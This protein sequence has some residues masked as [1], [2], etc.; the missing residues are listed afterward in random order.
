NP[1]LRVRA[2]HILLEFPDGAAAEERDSV[3]AQAE[4]L[5]SRI[6]E[7]E[8]FAELAQEYS[9]DPG[10][11]RRGG[12][13]GWFG[14]G[15]MVQPFEEAAFA[16]QPGEVS[17]VVESPFGLHI[18]R[19]DERES[20]SFEE[21]GPDFRQQAVARRQQES[22]DA[23]VE[24][25]VEPAGVEV[26]QGAVDIARDLARRPSERLAGRAASRR[27]VTWDDGAV[28][29]GEFLTV[30]QRF[31]PQQRA[32]LA[33]MPEQQVESMLETMATN[34]LVL[35]DAEARGIR[36]D[37]AQRDSVTTVLREQFV[38]LTRDAGL[39]SPP[40]EGETRQEAIDR[41]VRTLLQG[42]LSGQQGMLPLGA[43]PFSLRQRADWQIHERN[44][45][46]VVD[47]LEERRSSGSQ[48]AAP[49][50]PTT[51][52]PSPDTAAAGAAQDTA[53]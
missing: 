24:G 48:P 13:L 10:S 38:S 21:V 49:S 52:Q 47:R 40:Q 30:I 46:V 22:L 51:P 9:A 26:E 36:E 43:L 19:V 31:P 32:A 23:Y 34:E 8:D 44:F 53:G 7:G 33:T 6:L 27:L 20:P 18:I 15:Q 29:A 25:L 11:A 5:R 14:A 37:P 2:R 35:A 50:F 42:I 45:P 28:T 3:R 41:R 12:D 16:L 17:E 39:T 1:A 4:E